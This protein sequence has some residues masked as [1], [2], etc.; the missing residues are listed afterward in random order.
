MK[1]T[2]KIIVIVVDDDDD[3]GSDSDDDD[4]DDN[5]YVDYSHCMT[6]IT[7]DII[8]FHHYF[9]HY[10]NHT[11]Y[12]YHHYLSRDNDSHSII[13]ITILLSSGYLK[14]SLAP[15]CVGTMNDIKQI[16]SYLPCITCI[17]TCFIHVYQNCFYLSDK[18]YFD[19]YFVMMIPD[20]VCIFI[21]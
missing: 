3:Y 12:K 5:D 6:S 18:L 16:Y 17:H 14:D 11:S 4:D 8:I 10:H 1:R 7:R 2:M 15:G 19:L 9:N 13:I 21:V 20:H